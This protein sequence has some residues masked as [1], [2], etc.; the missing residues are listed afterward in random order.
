MSFRR[1]VLF[2]AV[3]AASCQKKPAEL[4]QV[5]PAPTVAPAAQQPEPAGAPAEKHP[6]PEAAP[7]ARSAVSEPSSAQLAKA[8][9][10]PA[11]IKFAAYQRTEI[12]RLP[13]GKGAGQAGRVAEGEQNPEA[14]MAFDVD[15]EGHVWLLDQVNERAVQ[16]GGGGRA[17]K[18]ARTAQDLAAGG[19]LLVLDRL[20][21]RQVERISGADWT[22][23][24]AIPLSA[25][26]IGEP[27][28]ITALWA[29]DGQAWLEIERTH[30]QRI[31]AGHSETRQGRLTRD[32]NWL[33]T[34]LRV[35]PNKAAVAGRAPTQA[36]TEAPKLAL[37]AE[38]PLPVW[39]IADLDSDHS[40]QIWLTADC[41]QMDEHDR[42]AKQLRQA[43]AWNADGRE[44]QRLTM[45][46]PIGPEE[47]FHTV[48]VTA[49]GAVYSMC[50][51]P[52]GL[53]IE[54]WAP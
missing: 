2:L 13:W 31:D 27:G 11:Q 17:V 16:M 7:A 42:P 22:Q 49:D 28:L 23:R 40:G 33:L 26:G 12:A 19:Q 50:R 30:W 34:A 52:Q 18:V 37:Q 20:V 47:Q 29:R 45:C 38:F 9:G 21:G 14:P 48:R 6:A 4:P 54:R 32:G 10:E 25:A 39:A 46:S 36:D 35:P 51:G 44:V 24:S 3:A 1:W 53:L 41:A 43:V 15:D 5:A 8:V